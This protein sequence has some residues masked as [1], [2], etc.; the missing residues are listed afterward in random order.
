MYSVAILPL[1]VCMACVLRI[2]RIS[3]YDKVRTVFCSKVDGPFLERLPYGKITGITTNPI[4]ADD[5]TPSY[6]EHA[7][8]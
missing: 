3:T 2:F 8:E 7:Q 5:I 1:E 6:S 4:L